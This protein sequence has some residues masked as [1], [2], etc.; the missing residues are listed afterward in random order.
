M[1]N[2]ASLSD[3]LNRLT[4]GNNGNPQNVHFWKENRTP[5]AAAAGQTSGMWD[6]Y[7][8]HVGNPAHGVVA[9]SGAAYPDNTLDGCLKQNDPSGG[10]QL[11]LVAARISATYSGTFVIYDRL[12]AYGG[13]NGTGTSQ[14]CPL[15]LSGRYSSSSACVGNEIWL[16]VGLSQIGA[17]GTTVT[18]SYTNQAGTS[19]RTTAAVT[20]GG[21]G[22]RETRR[23][24]RLPL[25]S[26]DSGV[27]AIASI[28]LGVSTGTAGNL[29]ALIVRPLVQLH[30]AQS[31]QTLI[32]RSFTAAFPGPVEI[33][34]DACLALAV[35][36]LS[37]TGVSNV[38]GQ[39]TLVEA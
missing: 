28:A 13:L 29:A 27:Q 31:T 23:I 14:S 4:G 24:L 5:G 9:A 17:T 20:I 1:G 26:G 35:C 8:T 2:L 21:T 39:L 15:T 19:G 37:A 10:R 18:A 16:E 33:Q 25:Q 3:V 11:W 34:T 32:M 12:A 38:C 22:Y 7:W 6:S 36:A 30:I